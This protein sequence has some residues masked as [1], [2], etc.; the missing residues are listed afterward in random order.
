M[1]KQCNIIKNFFKIRDTNLHSVLSYYQQ[2][3]SL[4]GYNKRLN[5]YLSEDGY[6]KLIYPYWDLNT[7]ST[8]KSASTSKSKLDDWIWDGNMIQ[9]DIFLDS[10]KIF[11]TK[12]LNASTPISINEY[13]I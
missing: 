6:R 12:T 10:H 11:E 1:I 9:K 13:V 5:L 2:E 4:R 7:F 3:Y 8:G